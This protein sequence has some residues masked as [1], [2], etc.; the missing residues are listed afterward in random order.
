MLTFEPG[1]LTG[2]IFFLS[3]IF[4]VP[5]IQGVSDDTK[6]RN[7]IEKYY[8]GSVNSST[9]DRIM[10]AYPADPDFVSRI[11]TLQSTLV[12]CVLLGLTL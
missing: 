12:Q 3:S 2:Q 1:I 7:F 9:V 6:F 4:S 5:V 8:V 10:A 11:F